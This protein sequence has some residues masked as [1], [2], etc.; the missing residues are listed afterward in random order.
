MVVVVTALVIAG[1]AVRAVPALRQPLWL[2]EVVSARIITQPTVSKSVLQV[3]KTESSP[4]GWHLTNW[5]L[6]RLVGKP[7]RLEWLRLLSVLFGG[8]LTALVVVYGRRV[9]LSRL[10][11][12]VAGALAAL[13]PNVVA[14]GAELR[15]YAALTLL[16]LIFALLLERAARCPTWPNLAWLTAVVIVGSYTHYFFL[17]GLATGVGWALVRLP[18]GVRLRVLGAIGVGL[19]PFLVWL[20]SFHY[21][22]KHN[23]YAYNGSF[24]VRAVAY[25]YA[26]IVGL[27]GQAGAVDALIRILFALVVLAGAAMLFRRREGELAGLMTV[28]PVALTAVIWILGPHIFNERNLLVSMPFAA[29]SVGKVVGQLPR[30]AMTVLLLALVSVVAVSLWD[31][32]VDYGRSSYNGIANALVADGWRS[33]DE[34]VQF[35]P[36]PLGLSQ[37]VGW[38][39]P[40]HPLLTGAKLHVCGP[41][42]AISYDGRAGDHWIATHLLPG[43]KAQTFKAYDHTPRG[44]SSSQPIYVGRISGGLATA[45]KA[46]ASGARLIHAEGANCR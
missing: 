36:A 18:K 27:L 45:K 14:H 29:V 43:G 15:P 26:R 2:D 8:A 11:A 28:A 23:L 20:P 32:E 19:L 9:G 17:L 4:P 31:W 5:A 12:L 1:V 3:R 22:Y 34:I 37:P 24:N 46:I 6:W 33:N 44:P 35:G 13:G 25:A 38:Y 16:A 30:P 40:G 41:L 7:S 39:L 10:G 42:F 21:Q